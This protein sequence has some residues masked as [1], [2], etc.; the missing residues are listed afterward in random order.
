MEAP[1]ARTG[2]IVFVAV[3]VEIVVIGAAC[4][5]WMTQRIANSIIRS[6]ISGGSDGARYF[7]ATLI[8]YNWRFA[9]RAD[10]HVHAWLSQVLM[11]LTV[12][13]VSALLIAAVVRGPV[14]FGRA[15]VGCWLAV[16]A[17]TM[18][19]SWVRG[20][21]RDQSGN[22][23]RITKAAFGDLGPN[24]TTFLAGVLLGLVVA[25]VAATF[26]MA[27][28]R[29]VRAAAPHPDDAPFFPPEQPPP[30]HGEPGSISSRSDRHYGP[31]VRPAGSGESTAQ[32]PAVPPEA[33]APTTRLPQVPGDTAQSDLATTRF[34]RPPDDDDLGHV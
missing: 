1:T 13:V 25:L 23:S 3:L 19:G 15:F 24:G 14:T 11:I 26:A 8:N 17:A 9:P 4:N 31:P 20:L 28:R 34:P 27:S 5:Q 12:L 29:P 33:A 7:K 6:Y 10:D 32:P 16:V 18:V 21:V 22:Q 30:Y 2:S